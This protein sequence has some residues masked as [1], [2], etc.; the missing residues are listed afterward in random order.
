VIPTHPCPRSGGSNINWGTWDSNVEVADIPANELSPNEIISFFK[1]A[2]P[3]TIPSNDVSWYI[4]YSV[5]W[6]WVKHY[7]S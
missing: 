1:R 3:F 6:T 5:E 4:Y 7:A 2:W